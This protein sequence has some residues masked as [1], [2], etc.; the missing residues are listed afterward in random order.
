ML[1][2]SCDDLRRFR[3]LLKKCR[4]PRTPKSAVPVRVHAHDGKLRFCTTLPDVTLTL[5][6]PCDESEV[7]WLLPPA[8]LELIDPVRDETLTVE[9]QG[10]FRVLVRG[11]P[12]GEQSLDLLKPKNTPL[13]SEPERWSE[14]DSSLLTVL[15]EA[16]RTST[17]ETVRYA[18]NRIQLQ[19]SSGRVVATDTKQALIWNGVRLPFAETVLVPAVPIFGASE[20]KRES[21]RIGRTSS[22][23][24]VSL[25]PWTVFLNIDS[26][27]KFPEVTNVI[28]RCQS[29]TTIA[30]SEADARFI[31]ANIDSWPQG[32]ADAGITLDTTGEQCVLRCSGEQDVRPMEVRL[33]SSIVTGPGITVVFDRQYLVRGLK[34]GF[35]TLLLADANKPILM[36]DRHRTY[37]AAGFCPTTAV[38]P[39]DDAHIVTSSETLAPILGPRTPEKL[40]PTNPTPILP[41]PSSDASTEPFE[42]AEAIR[43]LLAEASQRTNQLV[44]LLK[45]KRKADRAITQVVRSLQALPL[46][47]VS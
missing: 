36:T 23:V 4:P 29:P 38:L 27:G 16:G 13:F 32:E 7:D 40:M 30:I 14:A 24:V 18:V 15:H 45:A 33:T 19:G 2:L 39:H 5:T 42:E 25:G 10:K 22:H 46:K 44:Q 28:P 34:L 9:P 21:V 20:L 3:A 12:H 35:R 17:P 37:L 6:R 47:G 43:N 8:F 1:T 26:V 11:L 31:Q 41:R